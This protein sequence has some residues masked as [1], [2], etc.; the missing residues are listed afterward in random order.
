MGTH[1]SAPQ[2]PAE[3]DTREHTCAAVCQLGGEAFVTITWAVQPPPDGAGADAFIEMVEPQLVDT[4]V[5]ADETVALP[6]GAKHAA[7]PLKTTACEHVCPV[8]VQ[9]QLHVPALPVGPAF[10]SNAS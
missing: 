3:V 5:Q 1:A 10:A 9:A 7:S 6:H 8:A 2:L 4:A